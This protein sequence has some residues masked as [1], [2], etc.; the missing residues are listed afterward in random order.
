MNL[1]D[2]IQKAEQILDQERIEPSVCYET[3]QTAQ[4]IAVV[5]TPIVLQNERGL[6]HP[7]P[8]REHPELFQF[9]STNFDL[10]CAILDQI[11]EQLTAPLFSSLLSRISDASSFRHRTA[12]VLGAG[13]WKRCSSELPLLTEFLVRRGC[14]EL[15]ISAL[16]KAALGPGLTLL[17]LQLEEMIALNFTLFTDEEYGQI[18]RA[19]ESIRQ[20]LKYFAERPKPSST[21]DSNTVYNVRQEVPLLCDAVTEECRKARYLYVKGSLLPGMNLEVNQDKSRVRSFLQELGFTQLLIESLDEAER[22]YRAAATPFELKSSMGHVRSFLENLYIDAAKKVYAR[23]AKTG[24]APVKWGEALKFLTQ[25]GLLT[26]K[27]EEMVSAFYTL[28][29]DKAIHPLIAEREYARL[30]RNIAIEYGL[31]FLSNL[32]KAGYGPN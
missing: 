30:M 23:G 29:S 18:P 28:V 8:V 10:L 5:L 24:I 15:F 14:E 6:V 12:D 2:A 32:K 25:E 27:E 19:I 4:T 11:P 17:L 3:T 20:T 31:L 1:P 16:G 22:S 13:S 26:Q 21:V 9:K 7:R